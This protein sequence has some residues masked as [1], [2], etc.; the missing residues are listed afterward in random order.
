MT[1]LRYDAD[2][3]I[4]SV[5]LQARVS[6]SSSQGTRDEDILRHL[7]EELLTRLLPALLRVRER[8]NI[9]TERRALVASQTRYR[10]PKRAAGQKVDL[11]SWVSSDATTRRDLDYIDAKSRY[12]YGTDANSEP[13][14]YYLEW[15]DIVLV[16]DVNADPSG[17]IEI[18]YPFRPSQVVATDEVAIISTVDTGTGAIVLEGTVPTAFGSVDY[19]IHSPDSGGEVR[20]FQKAATL[21]SQT[22]TFT[23]ADIDGS[24]YGSHVPEAGDYVA[25]AGECGVP[26]LPLELHPILTKRTA[27]AIMRYRGDHE[28][29]DKMDAEIMGAIKD[30]LGSYLEDRV[31]SEPQTIVRSHSFLPNRW[32]AGGGANRSW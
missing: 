2:A 20:V 10:L 1:T 9:A 30:A 15:N 28:G 23:A 11:V 18:T 16:P 5:R 27:Q 32:G 26:F 31:E 7:H 25:L 17:S 29:A 19:D 4:E 21:S 6:D 12:R 8:Y 24:E 14:A 13:Q 22:L 3:L